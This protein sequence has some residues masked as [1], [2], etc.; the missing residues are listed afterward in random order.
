LSIVFLPFNLDHGG[1]NQ[2]KLLSSHLENYEFFDISKKGYLPIQD[3]VNIIKNASLVISSR[4]H[5]QV[6]ALASKIPAVSVLRDVLNDKRYYYNK[7]YGLLAQCLRNIPFNESLYLQLD[8]IEALN[9]ISDNF[10]YIVKLQKENYNDR[11]IANVQR[12]KKIRQHFLEIY[13]RYNKT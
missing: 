7:N 3:A 8:Y 12:L 1:E 9:F 5:A 13:L 10:D 11:Y 2:A 4:Y 6:L